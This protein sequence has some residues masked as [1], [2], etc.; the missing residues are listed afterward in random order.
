MSSEWLSLLLFAA[1]V[2]IYATLAGRH[3]LWFSLLLL[4]SALFVILNATELASN[5]FTGEGINDAVLYTLTNSLQGAGIGKYLLPAGGLM[6]A[7]IALFCGLAWILRG[8]RR[9]RYSGRFSL[10]A[11]L[12]ALASINTSPAWQQVSSLIR[13]QIRHGESDFASHYRVPAKTLPASAPN[14]VWIYVESLER[15]YL[16]NHHFPDLAPELNRTRADA[17][18]FSA[19]RQL[20]G[21]EY[22]I[23]GMVASQCGIPLFAPFDGNASSSMSTFYPRNVCLGDIL[24]ANGYENYFMQG[25]NL[26]FAG[27]DLFLR[28]HGFDHLY[29]LNELQSRVDEPDYRNDWGW[30][31][32]TVLDEVWQQY[33][34]LSQAGKRFSLFTLTVDTH[35]PDGFISRSCQRNRYAFDGKE[36]RSLAAVA[37][38]QEHVAQLIERIKASPWFKNTVI[39]VS[40]DHL[41][42][43]NTAF[44]YLNQHPRNNLFYVIRGD[45]PQAALSDAPRS[46]LD[47]GATVLDMLGGDRAMGLGRSSLAETSLSA[48]FPD[49]KAKILSWKPDIIGLWNLPKRISDYQVDTQ[50]GTFSFSGATY[51][52]PLLLRVTPHQV[53]P[54]FDV[55]I[56]ERLKLQL[57]R[58]APDDKF[59]WVD[60]CYKMGNVWQP[61]LM[62][63]V[64]L[65][66]ASGDLNSIPTLRKL[67]FGSSQGRVDFSQLPAGD[68]ATRARNVA[69]LNVP[70]SDFHYPS[71]SLI[72]SLPG[73]P[74]GVKSVSGL[75]FAENWG[76]WSDAN[77]APAVTLRWDAPLPAAFTLTLTA[78]ALGDNVGKPVAVRVGD[79]EQLISLDRE[80]K[81]VTLRFANPQGADSVVI[82]PPA[83]VSST[84]GTVEGAPTRK[85][86]VGLV[87][88]HI[89]PQ[90]D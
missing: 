45:R 80:A 85:L 3:R 62:T 13:S 81:S 63:D 38:S 24:K 86:G 21:T 17:L 59:V 67:P 8:R 32:D 11:L 47:N 14:L 7:L 75:S 78:K 58:F 70:D 28:S 61:A 43:N 89:Q 90:A 31:D 52:L 5:Y 53:E 56:V 74:E 2:A 15:T 26:S 88:V 30:Y 50:K 73:L 29:G 60:S 20:P 41:A 57:A 83:P 34:A 12:L 9:T 40:S 36:N 66:I 65:C 6:V 76:R 18:D 71:D 51:K 39:V 77:L 79:S 19:T 37:C 10:L 55:Y 72:F 35:H 87:R 44:K 42:M 22:T 49:I 33:V 54:K 4:L 23:A 27:K 25:A 69:R 48:V 84:L 68:D 82:V 64:G 46:T 1:A 16:D